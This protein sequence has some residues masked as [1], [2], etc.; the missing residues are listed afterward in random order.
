MMQATPSTD[1]VRDLGNGLIIRRLQDADREQLNAMYSE[2][3]H[4]NVVITTD[5]VINNHWRVGGK[6]LFI[7]VE[8]T[9]T[10]QVVSS[11]GLLGKPATYEG[12]PFTIGNPEWVLTRPEYRFKGLIRAQF[13]VLHEW[14]EARG[15][16]MQIISGIPNY[17]RQF[18]YDMALEMPQGR[19]GFAPSVPMLKEGETEPY[20]CRPATPDDAAFMA[21]ISATARARYAVT[22]VS[23]AAHFEGLA[24]H[25][26]HAP[27]PMMYLDII[28]TSEGEPVGYLG[29]GG[30]LF[31]HQLGI[32]HFEL[33]AGV[34]W[35][36]VALPIVRYLCA[37]GAEIAER[38]GNQFATFNFLLGTGHPAYDV[39]HDLLSRHLPSYAWYVRIRD[40]AGFIRHV[41]PALEA[42]LAASPLVGHTGFLRLN[43][44]R[45]GLKLTFVQG[46][47]VTVEPWQPQ[48]GDGPDN[49]GDAAFPNLTFYQLLL[50]YR[51]LEEMEAAMPDCRS[52]GGRS[53]GD[54][55]RALLHAIFPKR[56]SHIRI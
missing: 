50:G 8:D 45:H 7:V 12:I 27:Q 14:S 25:T 31:E 13:E 49:E 5:A 6:D 17:Y 20:R 22:D 54:G 44:Y 11:I 3:F 37:R 38:D 10:T 34:S 39:M 24:L 53:I 19:V 55:T 30:S 40:L 43:F 1:I 47:L 42:R 18:G 36:S 2:I 56:V 21:G 29:Y 16:L 41:A 23:D 33:K 32:R 52:I 9:A 28:E 51:S 35:L 26:Q 4:P 46:K 15:D 48:P